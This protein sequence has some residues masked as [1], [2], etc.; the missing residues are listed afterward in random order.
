M[1]TLPQKPPSSRRD[2]ER[3][4][5]RRSRHHD[6][7]RDRD[8]NG[9]RARDKDR[10]RRDRDR[11]RTRDRNREKDKDRNYHQ[12]R[13]SRR[14]ASPP[15][16]HLPKRPRQSSYNDK[17][18][19]KESLRNGDATLALKSAEIGDDFIPIGASDKEDSPRTEKH[20]PEKGK[21]KEQREWDVG[22]PPSRG[23]KRK[24][25]VLDDGEQ[26][27]HTRFEPRKTPWVSH[28]DWDTCH[29]VAEMYVFCF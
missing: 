20:R 2:R 19:G 21:E 18:E 15:P 3:D 12:Y 8:R 22:K 14:S 23:I 9:D 29:N 24:H 17:G 1:D 5:R 26:G 7:D 25:D 6:R 28:V 16:S 11:D 27:W 13:V 10:D 4:E